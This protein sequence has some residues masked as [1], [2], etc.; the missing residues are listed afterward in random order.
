MRDSGEEPREI[1]PASYKPLPEDV[2]KAIRII[3][4][5][6]SAIGTI[7]TV[8]DYAMAGPIFR[9]FDNHVLEPIVAGGVR[10]LEKEYGTGQQRLWHNDALGDD[11]RY[12]N[13]WTFNAIAASIWAA[14]ES[15]VRNTKEGTANHTP[16]EFFQDGMTWAKNNP[17]LVENL[18]KIPISSVWAT[19]KVLSAMKA[20]NTARDVEGLTPVAKAIR[21]RILT[22]EERLSALEAEMRGSP[23][24]V[25]L[26]MGDAAKN[27][28]TSARGLDSPL[29]QAGETSG[30]GRSSSS[31]RLTGFRDFV[32]DLSGYD[33]WIKSEIARLNPVN[34]AIETQEHVL[35]Y[36]R[37]T[38]RLKYKGMLERAEMMRQGLIPEGFDLEKATHQA[39]TDAMRDHGT[40]RRIER[41]EAVKDAWRE[42]KTTSGGYLTP[43]LLEGIV[44]ANSDQEAARFMRM[45]GFFPKGSLS[46]AFAH[47]YDSIPKYFR[48]ESELFPRGYRSEATEVIGIKQLVR[49]DFMAKLQ[50][51]KKKYSYATRN[52]YEAASA[53]LNEFGVSE[54]TPRNAVGTTFEMK[55]HRAMME[56]PSSLASERAFVREVDPSPDAIRIAGDIRQTAADVFNDNADIWRERYGGPVDKIVKDFSGS[57]PTSAKS[58]AWWRMKRVNWGRLWESTEDM[59]K[60][61]A[62]HQSRE[63]RKNLIDSMVDRLEQRRQMVRLLP[64]DQW[65]DNLKALQALRNWLT[66]IKRMPGGADPARVL[67]LWQGFRGWVKQEQLDKHG[68]YP[69]HVARIGWMNNQLAAG[70]SFYDA[71]LP[72]RMLNGELFTRPQTFQGA[73]LG[74]PES[75]FKYFGKIA[76]DIHEHNRTNALRYHYQDKARQILST[77]ATWDAAHDV[78][79]K[80]AKDM[81]DLWHGSYD[82]ARVFVKG[83]RHFVMYPEY[84]TQNAERLGHLAW[85]HPSEL[86]TVLKTRQFQDEHLAVNRN[87]AMQV[88]GEGAMDWPRL[89]SLQ[90]QVRAL[91]DQNHIY[92]PED[93]DVVRGLKIA[94]TMLSPLNPGLDPGFWSKGP[95]E[96]MIQAI[97]NWSLAREAIR[98]SMPE[99]PQPASNKD[100]LAHMIQPKPF[101]GEHIPGPQMTA[102]PAGTFPSIPEPSDSHA[103]FNRT[104]REKA[105]MGRNG[106]QLTW[107]QARQNVLDSNLRSSVSLYWLGVPWVR[108]SPG[109]QAVDGDVNFYN[110]D[111]GK[112]KNPYEIRSAFRQA[113]PDISPLLTPHPDANDHIQFL[114]DRSK[115]P[116]T[117][118]KAIEAAPAD[119]QSSIFKSLSHDVVQS[120][121][122]IHF[123]LPWE[124]EASAEELPKHKIAVDRSAF[125]TNESRNRAILSEPAAKELAKGIY[126]N[127]SRESIARVQDEV[128]STVNIQMDGLRGKTTRQDKLD[129]IK[130]TRDASGHSMLE[131]ALQTL[132]PHNEWARAHVDLVN[133]PKTLNVPRE[134]YIYEKDQKDRVIQRQKEVIEQ[135][136]PFTQELQQAAWH[137]P[138]RL[139]G[140][141]NDAKARM[142]SGSLPKDYF[143]SLKV[144]PETRDLYNHLAAASQHDGIIEARDRLFVYHDGKLQADGLSFQ[145]LVGEGKSEYIAAIRNGEAGEK[146]ADALNHSP[147]PVFRQHLDQVAP[148]GDA[149]FYHTAVR[150]FDH[151]T[152]V[153]ED[154]LYTHVSGGKPAAPDIIGSYNS[155]V[156]GLN[157]LASFYGG[158]HAKS[159]VATD[160]HKPFNGVQLGTDLYATPSDFTLNAYKDYHRLGQSSIAAGNDPKVLDNIQTET[161]A[162]HAANLRPESLGDSLAG[163]GHIVSSLGGVAGSVGAFQPHTDAADTFHSIGA[164]ASTYSLLSKGAQGFA[165]MAPE[166]AAKLAPAAPWVGGALAVGAGV[167]TMINA[168]DQE[169]KHQSD[170]EKYKNDQ[171]ERNKQRQAEII[172]SQHDN[173]VRNSVSNIQVREHALMGAGAG[174]GNNYNSRNLALSQQLH[175]FNGRPTYASRIGLVDQA[176]RSLG[177]SLTPRW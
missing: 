30:E 98:R 75:E 67:R 18:W 59:Q 44:R 135:T 129:Y 77:G 105:A 49:D 2:Q 57:I 114:L 74:Q 27:P 68:G 86:Q 41:M 13:T 140:L 130:S 21:N 166:T 162:K 164:A 71:D 165:S 145:H 136:K 152:G 15:V 174:G 32:K 156:G 37:Y 131:S 169:S 60:T 20:A 65:K 23:T 66:E 127:D 84:Y 154:P 52:D 171:Y 100:M 36:T 163:Y 99:L 48:R 69:L 6:K 113:H 80:Y 90:V 88:T 116:E 55:V 22:T 89:A 42:M 111:V 161:A 108:S 26:E 73:M 151:A 133:D 40:I 117:I 70:G 104:A 97:P 64:K 167:A 25:S 128:A 4:H 81:A 5:G 121:K 118:K 85:D 3:E 29:R 62:G 92:R 110:N 9:A 155:T 103:F 72:V 10:E 120:L 153:S 12:N 76:Q 115:D 147:D 170:I 19:T 124:S 47:A 63:M 119:K 38:L 51:V 109:H 143:T 106:E 61:V 8:I 79:L 35:A 14:K 93:S 28:P 112:Y 45:S 54:H 132:A 158:T 1:Q 134:T 138:D 142:E 91:A 87:G 159:P 50:E 101:D 139:P 53:L 58:K 173:M 149:F 17:D 157:S 144:A 150:N 137:A 172:A 122:D 24:R 141:V 94:Q 107:D 16:G 176:E 43:N 102:P 175:A 46:A 160:E 11:Y 148:R 83:L 126:G 78:A 146:Y 34:K 82:D 7:G 177:S 125:V 31:L 39:A 96:S 56:S 168:K 123:H 33:K 95:V